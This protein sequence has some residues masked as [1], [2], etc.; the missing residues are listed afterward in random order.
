MQKIHF[1]QV[2]LAEESQLLTCFNTPFGCFKFRRMPYGLN[3]GSEVFQQ[4]ME[5][6]FS[7]TPCEII[8]DDIIVWGVTTKQHYERLEQV[9]KR[10]EEI[11]LKFNPKKCQDPR[12]PSNLH[13]TCTIG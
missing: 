8:V 11:N 1:G 5:Q 6:A 7:G 10:A 2:P 9:L 13:W 3:S 4:A 12:G